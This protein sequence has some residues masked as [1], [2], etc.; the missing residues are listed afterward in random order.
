MLGEGAYRAYASCCTWMNGVYWVR[1]LGR[2]AGK[3][4]LIENLHDV[5]KIKVEHVQMS[6]E[7]DLIYN[8]VR[9]RDIVRWNAEPSVHLILT[10]DPPTR[11]GIPEA[12]MKRSY[13]KTFAYLKKFEKQLRGRSG[14][15][16]FF[17]E[18]DPFY[19][20][21]NV[22]EYSVLPFRVV[23]AGEVATSLDA[24]VVTQDS[25]GKPILTDQTAYQVP[26]GSLAE[27]DFLCALLNSMPVRAFYKFVAYK[28]TSM[29]FIQQLALP[30]YDEKNAQHRRIAELGKQAREMT[31]NGA[32]GIA[33]IEKQ[34]DKA[35]ARL[36]GISPETLAV[37]QEGMSLLTVADEATLID[38]ET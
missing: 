12:V 28:H 24:A 4:T 25:D 32:A 30:K 27:G 1:V 17:D 8:L 6:V 33:K 26:V 3:T 38:E 15:R 11:T 34:I 14:Y 37:I 18:S 16:K 19:S 21:Y 35:V 2:G 22:G 23:W 10:Q 9:G 36:W 13:P 7:P 29:N 5:G 20:V 31:R